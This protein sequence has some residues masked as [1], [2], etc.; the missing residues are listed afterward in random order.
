M[1]AYSGTVMYDEDKKIIT[2]TIG[3]EKLEVDFNGNIVGNAEGLNV[4]NDIGVDHKKVAQNLGI[5]HS[6]NKGFVMF[7]FS[8]PGCVTY[9][10][11]KKWITK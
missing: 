8:S 11:G 6:A 10:N 4:V 5:G 7:S 1:A 2:M 3:N 9:W